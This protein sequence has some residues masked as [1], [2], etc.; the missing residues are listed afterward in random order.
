L[1][2][3]TFIRDGVRVSALTASLQN[4]IAAAACNFWRWWQNELVQLLPA[5]IRS[6]LQH[7]RLLPVVVCSETQW[8]LWTPTL[9]S[10]RATRVIQT[11]LDR[12]TD[13]EARLFLA[14]DAIARLE[15][16]VALSLPSSM[17]LRRTL[18]LP[19]ALEEN[20]KQALAYDLDRHTPFRSD[21]L[22][23]DAQ[24]IGRNT[25]RGEIQVTLAATQRIH[26][27]RIMAQLR[28]AGAEI[29]ALPA[30]LPEN[31]DSKLNLL[32]TED[33]PSWQ[34]WQ[35]WTVAIG[36]VLIVLL[37]IA[38]VA[39]PVWQKRDQAIKL[40]QQADAMQIQAAEVTRL[41]DELDRLV[42][43]YDFVPERKK[44]YPATIH[45][46]NEI[47]RLLPDDTWLTQM[48]L[49]NTVG[50]KETRHE[51]FLR[52]ESAHASQLVTLLEESGLVTQAAPRSPIT[53]IQGAGSAGGEIFDIG[54]QIKPLPMPERVPVVTVKTPPLPPPPIL[55]PPSLLQPE[56]VPEPDPTNPAPDAAPAP[57]AI[58]TVPLPFIPQATPA[59]RAV[60]V[61]PAATSRRSR[62]QQEAPAAAPALVEEPVAEMA[63]S[64]EEAEEEHAPYEATEEGE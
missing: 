11:L 18:V 64:G 62:M 41:H 27:D 52:G 16:P 35:R 37:L 32:P 43:D 5:A 26:A 53:A 56:P 25:E 2:S 38:A 9:V 36:V 10:G 50:S 14:R 54:A 23:F 13:P 61:T 1:F 8:E 34:P 60:P 46:L 44:A 55:A 40:R 33:R 28:E 42:A 30:D 3:S 51:I 15:S 7:R 4:S 39:L 63:S 21:E 19:E 45:I 17:I 49:K 47:T 29:V 57:P 24:V 58:E 12:T 20:L 48:E 6:R 22:Y 31:I 59:P